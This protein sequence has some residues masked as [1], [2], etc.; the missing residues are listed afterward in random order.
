[1]VV[2]PLTV[3]LQPAT[4]VELTTAFLRNPRLAPYMRDPRAITDDTVLPAASE[5]ASE[6][7]RVLSTNPANRCV[8]S[9][10]GRPDKVEIRRGEEWITYDFTPTVDLLTGASVATIGL[11]TGGTNQRTWV[12]ATTPEM[13]TSVNI[14][15][16]HATDR[17]ADVARACDGFFAVHFAEMRQLTTEVRDGSPPLWS[18]PWSL[19]ESQFVSLI[20]DSKDAERITK[21]VVDSDEKLAIAS[22]GLLADLVRVAAGP[23]PCVRAAENAPYGFVWLGASWERRAAESCVDEC[24]A[25]AGM[26][27]HDA[28]EI[29]QRRLCRPSHDES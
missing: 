16:G 14:L 10:P 26:F 28:R 12:L 3:G 25:R 21:G 8:R 19:R 15:T 18:V 24:A 13:Q 17:K 7:Y 29:H 27:P 22:G 4:P 11:S 2:F 23:P 6:N 9:V 5:L 1:M 20:R